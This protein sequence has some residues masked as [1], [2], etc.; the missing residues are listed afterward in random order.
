ARADAFGYA[1]SVRSGQRLD[2]TIEITSSA[3]LEAFVDL[4]RLEAGGRPQHVASA[5]PGAA[6][7]DG[8]LRRR[9]SLDVLEDGEYVLR[10][11]PELLRGGAYELAI[12]SGPAL[13]FPV[14]GLGMRAVQSLF[15]AER[16]GGRRSHRGV[17]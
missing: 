15:G 5:A 8:P 4:Y 10:V 13:A 7:A 12:R 17:D 6:G 9:I 2:I 14:S 1:F 11:Q 16:D 3:E